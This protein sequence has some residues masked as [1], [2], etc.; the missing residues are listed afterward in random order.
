MNVDWF[1]AFIG[2]EENPPACYYKYC[3]HF[4][5]KDTQEIFILH[6]FDKQWLIALILVSEENGIIRANS[7]PFYAGSFISFPYNSR[8]IFPM[9]GVLEISKQGNIIPG[10]TTFGIS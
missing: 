10:I 3:W 9:P 2:I 7:L 6:F 5:F 4:S 1:M 8:I